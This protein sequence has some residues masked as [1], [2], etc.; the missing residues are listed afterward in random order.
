[1]VT[2]GPPAERGVG[3]PEDSPPAS[4]ADLS[5]A[6]ATPEPAPSA[7]SVALPGPPGARMRAHYGLG[8][9]FES[10]INDPELGRLVDST[11]WVNEAHP[12]YRRAAA[13]RSEGYHL[14]ISVATALAPLAVEPGRERGFVLAFLER[15]GHALDRGA[16]RV[17]R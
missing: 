6:I 1:M 14:A 3:I 8:I 5:T 12:A 10:R 9:Q 2:D 7:P 13:S 17:H 15:W 16:R 11:V 4:T